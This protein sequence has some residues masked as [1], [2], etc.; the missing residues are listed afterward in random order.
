[1]A[2]KSLGILELR[3]ISKGYEMADN[4]LKAGNVT[5]FTFR[6]TCPGKFLI[7]LQ[8]ASGELTSAMQDAKEEAGKFHVSSYI[9]HLV[10]EELL[11]FL[12]NK[13]TKVDIDAVGIIEISQLG[14]GLNAVNEAL[15][16]S[17]IHLKRMTLG[18]SIGGKFVAVFTG[19][20]SAIKEGMQI[21]IDTAEQKKVIHHT[22]IP[23]PDELLKRYL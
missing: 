7:I 15:K 4:F 8:G 1:M 9:I 5:L 19:E 3:S 14:A 17:A 20:V 22:I 16:K 12:Q 23:S 6:P 21:L 13:H 18:A 2:E 11:H 10:H